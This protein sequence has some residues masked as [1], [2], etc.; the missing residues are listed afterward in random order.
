MKSHF[1]AVVVCSFALVALAGC[2]LLG[3]ETCGFGA[4]RCKGNTVQV[5]RSGLGWSDSVNCDDVAAG[6]GGKWSCGSPKGVCQ[7]AFQ[8]LP[9]PERSEPAVAPSIKQEKPDRK[10]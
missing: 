1:I 3:I 7:E 10:R 8:C 4:T 6:E 9:S 2:S 5:C